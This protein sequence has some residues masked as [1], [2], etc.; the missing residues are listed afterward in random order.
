[1]FTAASAPGSAE[2]SNSGDNIGWK[3]SFIEDQELLIFFIA[4]MLI[5]IPWPFITRG[6]LFLNEIKLENAAG[7]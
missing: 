2:K 7:K 4:S 6:N 1:L 3:L 5:C